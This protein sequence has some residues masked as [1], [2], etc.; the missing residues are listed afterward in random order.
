MFFE[1]SLSMNQNTGYL[2]I[3][4]IVSLCITVSFDINL[5][6]DCFD[7]KKMLWLTLIC[8]FLAASW[9]GVSLPK[10]FRCISAPYLCSNFTTPRFPRLQAS[11]RGDHSALSWA[12]GFAPR[13]NRVR[14]RRRLPT[15]WYS[16]EYLLKILR[17]WK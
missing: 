9:S 8:P 16:I 6:K 11:W 4:V 10:P 1:I 12:L 7:Y 3:P 13:V 17:K 5:S 15:K 2:F 14:T